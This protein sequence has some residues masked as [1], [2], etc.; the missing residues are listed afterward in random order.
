M[1]APDWVL[2]EDGDLTLVVGAEPSRKMKVDSRTLRRASPVFRQMLSGLCR[3]SKPP[4]GSW[5]VSLAE[6][7]PAALLIIM[8]II[9]GQY[10][11]TTVEIAVEIL[12]QVLRLASKYHMAKALRPVSSAWLGYANEDARKQLSG[13]EAY[14]FVAHEL[15]DAG[16]FDYVGM[17]IVKECVLDNLGYMLAANRRRR[18][19][20]VEYV[21]RPDFVYEIKRCRLD[22]LFKIKETCQYYIHSLATDNLAGLRNPSLALESRNMLIRLILKEAHDQGI[23]AIFFDAV[24][25]QNDKFSVREI[26]SKLMLLSDAITKDMRHRCEKFQ[27]LIDEVND[28]IVDFD[29]ISNDDNVA[30]MATQA[31]A[32]QLLLNSQSSIKEESYL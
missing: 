1:D 31:A 2:D 28:A 4:S 16:L 18:L 29:S 5:E 27:V 24:D 30:Y 26:I 7:D 12:C 21:G 17:R 14:L 9:H 3:E 19:M 22:I 13:R 32:A 15:G 8:D 25:D 23:S 20:D 6:D 11:H 10:E